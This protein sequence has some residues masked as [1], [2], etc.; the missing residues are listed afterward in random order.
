MIWS[1]LSFPS[2]SLSQSSGVTNEWSAKCLCCSARIANS[3]PPS[4]GVLDDFHLRGALFADGL[5]PLVAAS[6]L[7]A[8]TSRDPVSGDEG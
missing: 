8:D 2:A 6:M 5:E 3:P 1:F 7:L 4:L